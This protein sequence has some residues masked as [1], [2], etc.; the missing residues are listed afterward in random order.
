MFNK[1]QLGGCLDLFTQFI[2]YL[3]SVQY[4]RL[5][6]WLG[7][8]AVAISGYLKATQSGIGVTACTCNLCSSLTHVQQWRNVHVAT[9]SMS[10]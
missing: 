5:F 7:T 9:H 3:V 4:Q 8:V 1:Y 2:T 10:V 6:L